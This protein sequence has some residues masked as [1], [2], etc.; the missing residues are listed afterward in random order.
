MKQLYAPNDKL[1]VGTAETV[2]AVANTTGWSECGDPIYQGGSNVDWDS[3]ST[4]TLLVLGA[5]TRIV[6]DEDG[7]EWPQTECTLR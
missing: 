2:R 5:E 7:D 4:R 6:V 1:I 3:Q